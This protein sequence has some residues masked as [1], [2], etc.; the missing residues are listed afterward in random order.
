MRHVSVAFQRLI[1]DGGAWF[2]SAIQCVYFS[3]STLRCVPASLARGLVQ[4][5]IIPVPLSEACHCC[6]LHCGVPDVAVLA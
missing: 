4:H 3:G 1:S 5:G 2:C 6:D